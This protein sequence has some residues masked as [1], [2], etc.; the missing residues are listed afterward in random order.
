MKVLLAR[1]VGL[2]CSCQAVTTGYDSTSVS[3]KPI[4]RLENY[5]ALGALKLHW[6]DVVYGGCKVAL[7]AFI[8]Q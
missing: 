7:H 8:I 3:H 2:K 1:L 6:D 4:F 5:S